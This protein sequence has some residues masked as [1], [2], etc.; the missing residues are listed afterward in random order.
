MAFSQLV[1]AL[2]KEVTPSIIYGGSGVYVAGQ[3]TDPK[4]GNPVAAYWKNG[5]PVLLTNGATGGWAQSIFVS[6]PDVYVAGGEND[7]NYFPIEKYWKN[8]VPFTLTNCVD[9]S[10]LFVLGSDVY[11]AGLAY[12][13]GSF[14]SATY[15]KNG[16]P[17]YL[18]DGTKYE[19]A[20][21]IV[22]S[23]SDVYVAGRENNFYSIGN[24]TN[25]IT[26]AK[27]WKNDFP[28]NLTDGTHYAD[29]VSIA[30][31]GSDVYVAGY[32][33][34]GDI[35]PPPASSV[36]TVAKY[37]KNGVAV[38]LSDGT[39]SAYSNSIAV[40]GSDVYVGGY[41]SFK[42][43]YLTEAKYWKNSQEV[44][45]TD[46]TSNAEAFSIC[47]SGTDVY[48]AGDENN[49]AKYWKNGV[50]V[51]LDGTNLAHANSIFVVP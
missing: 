4:T 24:T 10:S 11:V 22:V 16:I 1:H 48:V 41:E 29:A 27:Y 25:N 45:L 20:S 34:N 47:V 33:Y 14:A 42:N 18:S 5:I 7:K 46:G 51:V 9:I 21:S 6:G 8:G 40:S 36:F 32:E 50:A 23:G 39:S 49:V 19:Y 15:W 2:K 17:V 31:S 13:K 28:F 44:I 43:F 12:S 3:T 38:D 37:W 35:P 30:V 26:I